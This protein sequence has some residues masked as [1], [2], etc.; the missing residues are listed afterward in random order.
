MLTKYYEMYD[1]L[2]KVINNKRFLSYMH[3]NYNDNF[4]TVDVHN[5]GRREL[6]FF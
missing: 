3:E 2:R 1:L 5:F 4:F 6:K